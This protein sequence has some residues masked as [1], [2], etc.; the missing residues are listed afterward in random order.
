MVD[1]I[2]DHE[3]N[4]NSCVIVIDESTRVC[5]FLRHRD[6]S[7]LNCLDVPPLQAERIRLALLAS[8]RYGKP[9]VFGKI[10][11]SFLVIQ[12]IVKL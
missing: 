11:R 4:Q 5:A 7:F 8:I 2:Y 9:L 12:L 1:I 6:V 10:L 3:Q